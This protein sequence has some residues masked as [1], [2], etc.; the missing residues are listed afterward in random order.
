MAR[1]VR[2]GAGDWRGTRSAR[3]DPGPKRTAATKWTE[4]AIAFAMMLVV[5]GFAVWLFLLFIRPTNPKTYFVPFWVGHVS[6]STGD[7]DRS[8]DAGR[9]RGHRGGQG[10]PFRENRQERR[11]LTSHSKR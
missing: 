7:T 1:D 10:S 4:A 9:S 2:K 8:V 3:S 11:T 6:G 5:A